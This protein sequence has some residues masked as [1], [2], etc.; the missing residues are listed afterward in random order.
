MNVIFLCG[1]LEPG[2]DGVGDYTRRLAG[3]LC[4]RGHSASVVALNDKAVESDFAGMQPVDGVEI[5]VLRLSATNSWQQRLAA[6]KS[7]VKNKQANWISLQYVPF[8]FHNK[9]LPWKLGSVLKAFGADKNWHIMFHEL[10][11]GMSDNA[12]VKQKMWGRV[13][14]F[15]IRSLVKTLQPRV[16]QTH[17][18][19]YQNLLKNNGVSASLLPLFGNVPKVEDE[20]IQVQMKLKDPSDI[21]F[22]LFGGIHPDAPVE[23][24]AQEAGHYQ[25]QT[26]KKISLTLIGRNGKE[27]GKWQSAWENAGLQIHVLGAQE[28]VV[29]SSEMQ[30]ATIGIATTPLLLIEKSGSAATML[31]HGL[32]VLCISKPWE[33]AGMGNYNIPPGI[34]EYHPGVLENLFAEKPIVSTCN[35]LSSVSAAFVESLKTKN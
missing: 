21:S 2:K 19:L 24:L 22:L 27:A 8:S 11:V 20:N 26:G 16:V 12:S 15:L 10:W 14:R 4:R 29:I 34:V 13:Q 17:V 1:S 32:P 35:T 25:K 30:K 31:E 33:V 3:E 18:Q 23:E 6:M 28:T 5:E 9:G 7:W